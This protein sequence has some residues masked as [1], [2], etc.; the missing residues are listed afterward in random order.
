MAT[1][2]PAAMTTSSKSPSSQ[3]PPTH[4]GSGGLAYANEVS[5]SAMVMR[6]IATTGRI[7]FTLWSLAQTWPVFNWLETVER[8]AECA[9]SPSYGARGSRARRRSGRLTED[10]PNDS[11]RLPDVLGP[12]TDGNEREDLFGV[13]ARHRGRLVGPHV[14]QLSQRHLE[15]DRHPVQAVDGD[16]FLAALDL[17]DELAGQAGAITQ[18]LLAESA[19]LA[20]RPQPLPQELPYVFHRAFAH[21]PV[22]LRE[23]NRNPARWVGRRPTVPPPMMRVNPTAQVGGVIGQ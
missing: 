12:P 16:R 22:R 21:G 5:R 10:R 6:T 14:R 2:D 19:L 11:V 18:P 13:L 3:N 17:A 7:K 15:R 4:V 9:R 1:A 20:E 23:P 8:S